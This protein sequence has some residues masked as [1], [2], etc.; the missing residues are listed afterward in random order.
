MKPVVS[1]K[2]ARVH[3][4]YKFLINIIQDCIN[5]DIWYVSDY[6]MIINFR[7]YSVEHTI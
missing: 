5:F 7:F 1:F 6:D 3:K 4:N 2:T